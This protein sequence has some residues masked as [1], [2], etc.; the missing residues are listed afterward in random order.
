[1]TIDKEMCHL[2][3]NAKFSGIYTA[4]IIP[5]LNFSANLIILHEWAFSKFL[6]GFHVLAPKFDSKDCLIHYI[7][8]SS[9]D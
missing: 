6:V 3:L 9:G 7:G 2:V 1:M 8:W 5:K 4:T